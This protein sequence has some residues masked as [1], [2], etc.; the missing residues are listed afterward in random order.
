MFGL[1]SSRGASGAGSI[2]IN[3]PVERVFSFIA[4]EEGAK[5]TVRNQRNLLESSTRLSI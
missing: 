3:H 2:V 4:V 5:R 1:T